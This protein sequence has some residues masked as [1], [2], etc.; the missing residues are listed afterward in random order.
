MEVLHTGLTISQLVAN[1]A[2]NELRFPWYH[3]QTATMC[4]VT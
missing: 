2:C 1:Y 4:M 3:Y